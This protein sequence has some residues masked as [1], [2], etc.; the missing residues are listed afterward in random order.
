MVIACSDHD[1]VGQG[2]AG[3]G[4]AGQGRAGGTRY[5]SANPKP[6][7][8]QDRAGKM[9]TDSITANMHICQGAH[10]PLLNQLPL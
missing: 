3:Q 6:C 8:K 10:K 2:R 7:Q 9:Q 5:A 1:Q 4:R